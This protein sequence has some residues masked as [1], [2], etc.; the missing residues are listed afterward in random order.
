MRRLCERIIVGGSFRGCGL[1]AGRSGTLLLEESNQLGSDFVFGFNPGSVWRGDGLH[2][3]AEVFRKSCVDSVVL[4]ESGRVQ[5]GSLASSIAAWSLENGVEAELLSKV[6]ERRDSSLLVMNP[7]GLVEFEAKEIIDARPKPGT[8]KL[9]TAL[10]RRPAGAPHDF[11][12]PPFKIVPGR[13]DDEAYLLME[14]DVSTTW[15]LA[16]AA[17]HKAWASRPESLRDWRLVLIGTRFDFMEYPSPLLALD[18]GLKGVG[19]I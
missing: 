12:S 10:L 8:R 5:V 13:F 15:S 14:L 17:F 16:R 6:V 2:P 7:S 4:D 11:D 1:A 9:L 3:L 19:A 18:A